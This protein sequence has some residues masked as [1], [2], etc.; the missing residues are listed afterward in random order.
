MT[1]WNDPFDYIFTRR[2]IDTP[3]I[4][5]G[6][7]KEEMILQV[8]LPGYSRS[9]VDVEV[10]GGRLN[11]RAKNKANKQNHEFITQEFKLADYNQTWTLPKAVNSDSV[12]ANY[13][14][15]ILTVTMPFAKESRE[16]V[17][18]IELN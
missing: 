17:R 6:Q 2:T 14:A 3:R 16:G 13:E 5:V 12:S 8:A 4:N 11:V 15:G 1:Y 10:T 7:N 9:D 18:K